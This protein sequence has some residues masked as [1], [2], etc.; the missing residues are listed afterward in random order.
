MK[1]ALAQTTR[2]LVAK[3][4]LLESCNDFSEEDRSIQT[5][6][7][8]SEIEEKQSDNSSYQITVTEDVLPCIKRSDL[9]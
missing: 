2:T 5:L 7:N 8:M 9:R 1:S 4:T 3:S 6:H